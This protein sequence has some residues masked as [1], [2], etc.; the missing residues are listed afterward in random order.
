MLDGAR[1]DLSDVRVERKT[2]PYFQDLTYVCERVVTQEPH[3]W[4]GEGEHRNVGRAQRL[5][6]FQE[7]YS[8]VLAAWGDTNTL[9]SWQWGWYA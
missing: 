5:K 7:N 1:A 6:T 9:H 2:E 4:A 3:S 8:Q